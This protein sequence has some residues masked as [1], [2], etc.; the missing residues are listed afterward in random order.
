MTTDHW[1]ICEGL[2]DQSYG[3]VESFG[4]SVGWTTMEQ[5]QG[6]KQNRVCVLQD[7]MTQACV[8]QV[9][10]SIDR[11]AIQCLLP[12]ST[13]GSRASTTP[14]SRR[15]VCSIVQCPYVRRLQSRSYKK[16]SWLTVMV[17]WVVLWSA[18]SICTRPAGDGK[19]RC[20]RPVIDCDRWHSR[21]VWTRIPNS[22]P[23]LE[24]IPSRPRRFA[25]WASPGKLFPLFL[26]FHC[27]CFNIFIF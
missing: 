6:R 23:L 8:F 10:R 7:V 22:R 13:A 12:G 20:F 14:R 27:F 1:F 4:R 24:R 3:R 18:C 26:F 2:K 17:T 15:F 19:I 9:F 11:S 5:N 25:R 21:T 16:A